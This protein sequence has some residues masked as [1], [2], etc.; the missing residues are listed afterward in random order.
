MINKQKFYLKAFISAIAILML[1]SIASVTVNAAQNPALTLTKIPNPSTYTDGQSVLYTY[2][3]TNVGNVTLSS[4]N[5]TDTTFGQTIVLGTTTL[6]PDASTTGTFTYTTTQTDFDNG[7]VVDNALAEGTF[8]SIVVQAPASATVTAVNQNPALIL[9]KIPNSSTYN[10]GQSITYTY[11]I[12]NIGNTELNAV[13]MVDNILGQIALG[14][15][16]LKPGQSTTGQATY[17]TTPADYDNGFVTNTATVY[18]GTVPFNTTTATITAIN[19]NPA[20]TI[21]KSASPTTY[22]TVGQNIT[23]IYTV[24]NSGNVNITGPINII[25]SLINGLISIY[26]TDL[27]PGQSVIGTENY[28]ITQTD[29]NAGSVTNSAYATN[30]NINSNIVNV[31]VNAIQQ[32][33]PIIIWNNPTDIIYG[34]PLS[35]AQ[36]DATASVPGTFVYNPPSGTIL[37]VG[38]NQ[39]LNTIFIPTDTINYTTASATSSINV[40]QATPTIIWN[41][42][43]DIVYGTPLSDAQLDA[44]AV[45]HTHYHGQGGNIPGIFTYTPP[46]GTVLELGSYTLNVSFTP[47]DTTNYTTASASVFINV[48]N[49]TQITQITPTIIWNNPADIVY[50]TPLSDIQLNAVAVNNTHHG[51]GENLSGIFTYKPPNGTILGVGSYMLNVFFTPTDTIYY[52]T[53]SASVFINV[54]NA[55]QITQITPTITWNNPADIIYGT[56]LSDA[57]LD[58]TASVPGTFVYN[59]PSGTILSVGQNQQ[60]NTIF[61]PTD[62]INYTTASATSSI[63]VTQA[64]PTVIWNNPDD[65]VYGTQLSGIQLD[66]NAS[67]P[68]TFVY[69]PPSGTVLNTGMHTLSVSFTPTDTTN[70][71]TASATSSINVS[72]PGTF[73]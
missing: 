17:I 38:Q 62:T 51:H 35:D 58:A 60:L 24:T 48:L 28:T 47:T 32:V 36:L 44:V 53:A 40:T 56:P 70:Y 6:A 31:T 25:D 27:G 3:V 16:D 9:T 43:A 54:L 68:G 23:Y 37:S 21:T 66:A 59:P 55:T 19:Q 4:V 33:I 73:V 5:V 22:S 65:I 41:S 29:I 34:T 7:S 39:Q 30:N 49:A 42:P 69:N 45:V 18:N 26:N 61:I 67:A 57:Q 8:K 71:T 46:N 11:L 12:T 13:N 10:D 15:T 1:V 52:T 14:N 63:N 50:G 20:L 2:T 64:T 72:V